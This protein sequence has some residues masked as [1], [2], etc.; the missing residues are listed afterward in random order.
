M[1][2]ANLDLTRLSPAPLDIQLRIHF[3]LLQLSIA[4]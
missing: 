3:R 4:M 2:L 1:M